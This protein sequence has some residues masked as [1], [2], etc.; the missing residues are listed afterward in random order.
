VLA[1]YSKHTPGTAEVDVDVCPALSRANG[2]D[3]FDV[4]A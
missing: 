3:I 1:T 2:I 4:A